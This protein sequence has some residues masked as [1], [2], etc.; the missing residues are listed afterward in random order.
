[1]IFAPDRLVGNAFL[2]EQFA[3]LRMN[4]RVIAPPKGAKRILRIFHAR[5]LFACGAQTMRWWGR[6][7]HQFHV[8]VGA[9]RKPLP[10][11]RFAL[12]T[13]HRAPSLLHPELPTSPARGRNLPATPQSLIRP[14]FICKI[15]LD[16]LLSSGIINPVENSIWSAGALLPLFFFGAVS[17]L[18]ILLRNKARAL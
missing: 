3:K 13:I 10:I 5:T 11:L 1:M 17:R 15:G 18:L 14:S 2:V 4:A 7:M 8:A 6:I 12:W 9:A 16:F